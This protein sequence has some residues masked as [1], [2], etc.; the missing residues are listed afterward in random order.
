MEGPMA[1]GIARRKFVAALGAAA[2]W[3]LTAQ[4]QQATTRVPRIG[5]LV[6]GSPT[7]YRFDL[8]AFR[9]GLKSLNYIEGQNINIEYR[10]AEGNTARLPDLAV[11]LVQQKVDVILAGGAIGAKAAMLAT[12]DIPIVAAG[13][14][15]LVELGLVTSLA[16]PGGNLTGFVA[17]APETAAKRFQI[18]KEIKP[19]TRRAAVLWN[20]TNSYAKLEWQFA[21]EFAT[22]NNI[23]VALHDAADIV[24]LRNALA[25]LPQ[26]NPDILVVLNDAFVFT[27][28]KPIID[29]AD[30][31]QLPGIY[32]FREFVDDGGL[33]S[34]GTSIT[35]T[36][37]RAADYVDKILRGANPADL[38]VQLPTK[39]ELV[40]NLKTAKAISFVFPDS[41]LLRADEVIE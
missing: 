19:Q 32:G 27:N 8:A 11:E 13:A 40:V 1:V 25:K 18:M 39:S 33:I 4:A 9:D 5:W 6:T 29:A 37:R 41:F 2:A 16:K 22:S 28:R 36:Y 21:N 14:G 12:S 34:Y 31:S 17:N 30:R 3:P 7:S 26:S 35:D 24:Q 15:D 38:P 10:W 20:P 23:A